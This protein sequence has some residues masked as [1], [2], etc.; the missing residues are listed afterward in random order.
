MQIRVTPQGPYVVSDATPPH[1]A[2]SSTSQH[3]CWVAG[4]LV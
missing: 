3:G 1:R 2:R 4:L